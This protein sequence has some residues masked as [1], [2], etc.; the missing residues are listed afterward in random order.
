MQLFDAAPP[1]IGMVHLL[2]LPETPGFGGDLTAVY[3]QAIAD[4]QALVDAGIDALIIENF[5]DEPYL[6]GEPTSA[7]LSVMSAIASR[8]RQMTE[9]PIGVNV[10][11]N[12]WQAE[13]ALAYAVEAQ[14]V[15]V[16]VFVDTVISAQGQVAPCSAQ[17]TRYRQ[18]LGARSVQLWAD[19]QTKYT[20]NVLPQP[21]TQS[22]L[23]AE[24][25][26]ADVLIVTGAATGQATPLDAVKEVKAVVKIPVVVGSG[27]NIDNVGDVLRVA[28]GAIVGSALKVD[29]KAAN[30]VSA[31]RSRAFMQA[32]RAS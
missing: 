1:I 22:A 26:G 10:Q 30:S 29:G 28:D 20:Q 32:A 24:A 8:I 12:A 7:Q 17:I 14:F 21:I 6:I 3:D 13:I 4:T 2:P 5:G 9:I 23:D 18:R 31:E 15:R 25:A 19:I 11:F 16:E 27:T